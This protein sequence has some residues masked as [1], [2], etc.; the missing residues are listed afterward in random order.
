M[1]LSSGAEQ[2]KT[3][4]IEL[5]EKHGLAVVPSYSMEISFHDPLLI[6]PLDDTVLKFLK[7][8]MLEARINSP[9]R[10]D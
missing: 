7:D 6:V 1:G 2:F 4:F 8:R 5:C 3:E 9:W 10:F